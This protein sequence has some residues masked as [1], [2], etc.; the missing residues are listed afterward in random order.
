MLKTAAVFLAVTALSSAALADA[1]VFQNVN[2]IP[3]TSD[4]VL[5]N[6]TVIVQNGR[7]TAVGKLQAKLPAGTTVIDGTGKYLAPGLAEMH[8]HIPPPN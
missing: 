1:V 8:G 4:K 6:Q 7:I 2:V 5:R 3:M